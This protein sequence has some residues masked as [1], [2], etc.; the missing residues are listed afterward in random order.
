W[1]SS[2]R[3][4]RAQ[5]LPASVHVSQCRTVSLERLQHSRGPE[6]FSP[7]HSRF[8]EPQSIPIPDQ[9]LAL[10]SALRVRLLPRRRGFG[11]I[12]RHSPG[13]IFCRGLVRHSLVAPCLSSSLADKFFARVPRRRHYHVHSAW[14][15]FLRWQSLLP[16]PS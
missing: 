1:H 9:R 5:E 14:P 15:V 16:L 6:R 8:V 2:A 7:E 3:L 12:R 11:L 13:A 4:L 10:D